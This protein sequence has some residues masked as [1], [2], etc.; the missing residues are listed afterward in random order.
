MAGTVKQGHQEV[1]RTALVKDEAP[2]AL[3]KNRVPMV[4]TVLH[5]KS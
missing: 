1:T 5:G 2:A 3:L 4:T